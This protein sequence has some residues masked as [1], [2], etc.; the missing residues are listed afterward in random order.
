MQCCEGLYRLFALLGTAGYDNE[1][2]QRQG[3]NRDGRGGL[4]R[5][6]VTDGRNLSDSGD[7]EGRGEGHVASSKLRLSL[8]R[9]ETE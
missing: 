5:K 3:S 4:R 2:R 9:Y 1:I 7:M 8:R 6:S